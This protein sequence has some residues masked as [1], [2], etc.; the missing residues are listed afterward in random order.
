MSPERAGAL[1]LIPALTDN[2]LT[3]LGPYTRAYVLPGVLAFAGPAVLVAATW[4]RFWP[5]VLGWWGASFAV[6]SI[7]SRSMRMGLTIGLLPICVLTAFEGGLFMLPAAITLLAID[8]SN[9]ASAPPKQRPQQ[10]AH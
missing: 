8:A 7:R 2:D 4:G 5:F 10:S 1:A 6:A 9:P 3:M